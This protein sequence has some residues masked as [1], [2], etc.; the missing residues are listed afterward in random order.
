MD[1]RGRNM[2]KISIYFL[3]LFSIVI[4]IAFSCPTVFSQDKRDIRKQSIESLAADFALQDVNG[5]ETRLSDYR[6]KVVLINFS[7]T[8]CPHCRAITSYLKKLHQEYKDRGLIILNVDIQESQR[9]VMSFALKYGLPYRV[10]LD[11][12]AEVARTYGIRGVPSLILV[13]KE[14]KIVCRQCRSVD[15]LLETLLAH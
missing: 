5:E 7:T 9:R 2:K 10:L 14:G 4:F 12:S 1:L 13:N 3:T 11:K 6:G 15:L 8:W